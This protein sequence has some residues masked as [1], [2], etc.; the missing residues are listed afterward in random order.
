MSLRAIDIVMQL[1]HFKYHPNPLKTG[2]VGPSTK[3]CECCRQARGYMYTGHVYSSQEVEFIC[4]WCIADGSVALQMDGFLNDAAPLAAAG[5][6][7]E[8]IAEVEF[9]TPGYE[10]LQQDSWMVCCGDACEF[11]GDASSA[12]I[13]NL[14]DPELAVLSKETLFPL[15]FLQELC[16]LYEPGGSPAFYK[17]IC[18]HCASVKY[19][20]DCD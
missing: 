3:T 7:D 18:R 11:H 14:G 1:P 12:D 5:L 16:P 9:K 20:G 8:I 17:F 15:E 6:S 2:M 4:P 10:C 19:N 13:R